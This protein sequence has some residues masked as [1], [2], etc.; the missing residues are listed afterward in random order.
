MPDKRFPFPTSAKELKKLG[1]N[2]PDIILISGDAFIDH[3]SFG[4]AIIARVLN[5]AGFKVAIV[6]QPNWKDDFRDF[7]KFGLPKLFFAVT[8][9]NMD[10]MI[11]HYTANKRIRS[12]DAYTPGGKAGFR[13]DYASVEYSKIL[14]SLFPDTPIVLGGI[15]ASMR[16]FTHYDYWKD[17]LLPSILVSS[18]ADILCYGMSEKSILDIAL[19]INRTGHFYETLDIPQIA[20]TSDLKDSKPNDINLYSHNDCVSNPDL[21]SKNFVTV[22]T[23]TNRLSSSQRITQV[24]DNIKIIVNPP[25]PTLKEKELDEIYQLPFTRL[26]HP[27][28]FKKEPIPAFE[29]IKNSVTIHRGCFGACSFCTIAAHQ[30]KFISSRSKESVLN[31]LKEIAKTTG[32]KGYISDLG[33]PS[34]NM[35]RMGGKNLKLCKECTKPSCIYPSICKNLN[36]SHHHLTELYKSA[37]R[38]NGIKKITIGSGI[39]YDICIYKSDDNQ[40]NIENAKY[41]KTL[42]M[43]HV[44]GRLKVAPEH[45]S[46]KVLKEMRKTPFRFF[47]EL[48]VFF[49]KIN[50]THNLNQQLIP[51]FISAHPGC[52]EEDMAELATKTASLGFNL[53][54]VQAFTP[55]PMTLSSVIYY[56]GKNPYTGKKVYSAKNAKERNNQLQYF[57]WYNKE[58]REKIKERLLKM[59]RPDL[60]TKL[61]NTQS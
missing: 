25:N 11:N 58:S 37:S 2:Q 51:Y 56:T 3:P 21:F 34:A 4:P 52:T 42:I 61:K 57:F 32:F 55:T 22:E 47:K 13:P 19:S 17:E 40:T 18:K 29:M 45:T 27:K 50:S 41:L 26:P 39:R 46:S 44:S 33:G 10:S 59:K 28:Y 8:S 5:N 15:E 43:N 12:D 38:I 53:E 31:E 48:K 49:D 35:Y 30:G 1:W 54:Q 36:H 20:Y 23:L 16:R 60:I 14:K 9:G 7:K 24:V 6:P